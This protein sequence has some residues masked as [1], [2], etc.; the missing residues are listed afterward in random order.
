[1]QGDHQLKHET[2]QSLA[3]FLAPAWSSCNAVNVVVKPNSFF[4]SSGFNITVPERVI[5]EELSGFDNYR[6]WRF[7]LWHQ[8][9]HVRM[10]HNLLSAAE[11]SK[12]NL[13]GLSD[14]DSG[15][16]FLD[17]S[18]R[19]IL[20]DYY[21]DI[22]GLEVWKGMRVEHAFV[23]ALLGVR[24]FALPPPKG[25]LRMGVYAEYTLQ[26][27]AQLLLQGKVNCDL[28]EWEDYDKVKETVAYARNG[29]DAMVGNRI[30]DRDARLSLNHL[31]REV[32]VK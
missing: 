30:I 18:V 17:L 24:K 20:E 26:V 32:A 31:A 25:S 14:V 15:L 27:F 10:N 1:V 12:Q 11:A 16:S 2:L 3:A 22:C 8:A 21:V 6:L 29:I 19:N 23:Q 7:G 13:E 4:S 5:F 28:T 9:Q